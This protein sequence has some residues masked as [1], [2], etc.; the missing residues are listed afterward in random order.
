M[1]E[2]SERARKERAERLRKEIDNLSEG[3]K[4]EAPQEEPRPESAAEFVHRR[5]HELDQKPS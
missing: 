2:N 1:L 3:K 4:D 5:M